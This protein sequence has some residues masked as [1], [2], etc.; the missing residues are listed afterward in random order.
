MSNNGSFVT[1]RI[2]C[3]V[4]YE[5]ASR[6]LKGQGDKWLCGVPL[7]FPSGREQGIIAGMVSDSGDCEALSLAEEEAQQLAN[8]ICHRMTIAVI[9]ELG[10]RVDTLFLQ[11]GSKL[12]MAKAIETNA[13]DW[14]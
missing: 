5:H 8:V 1:S 12:R 11:P 7:Q 13:Q 14:P 9:N 6:I 10:D 3:P 4:C 2:V